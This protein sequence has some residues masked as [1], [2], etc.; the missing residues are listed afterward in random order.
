MISSIG[1]GFGYCDLYMKNTKLYVGKS[2]YYENNVS[3]DECFLTGLGWIDL[4]WLGFGRVAMGPKGGGMGGE[5]GLR[6]GEDVW[7]C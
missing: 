1:F 2:R 7:T 5:V 6:T 3:G 4:E